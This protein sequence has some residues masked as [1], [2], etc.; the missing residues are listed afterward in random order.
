MAGARHKWTDGACT[1]CL[2]VGGSD[3]K[4]IPA[5]CTRSVGGSGKPCDL[6]TCAACGL[7]RRRLRFKPGPEPGDELPIDRPVT[8]FWSPALGEWVA[9]DHVPACERSAHP[10]TK[11]SPGDDLPPDAAFV[12]SSVFDEARKVAGPMPT[13]QNALFGEPGDDR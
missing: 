9:L 6:D 10:V 12:A 5:I 2:V 11:S 4:F 3:R 7:R 8:E 13:K 1:R